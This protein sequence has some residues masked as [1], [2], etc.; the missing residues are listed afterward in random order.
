MDRPKGMEGKTYATWDMEVEKAM[1]KN[2]VE[3]DGGDYSKINMIPSNVT[4]EVTALEELR[5]Q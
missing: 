5:Q 1:I 3:A 2:V 4:D